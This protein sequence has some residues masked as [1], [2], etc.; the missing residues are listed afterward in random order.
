[1]GPPKGA[2]DFCKYT[3]IL[4]L[5]LCPLEGVVFL[6]KMLLWEAGEEAA[7]A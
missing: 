1:M 6:R 5:K 3:K 7:R 4:R 2:V